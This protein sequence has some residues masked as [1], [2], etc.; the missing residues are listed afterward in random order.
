MLSKTMNPTARH[1]WMFTVV[2]GITQIK[3]ANLQ[4]FKWD[5]SQKHHISLSFRQM[6]TRCLTFS[7]LALPHQECSS[8]VLQVQKEPLRITPCDL[9]KIPPAKVG[10][11]ESLPVCH[12][13]SSADSRKRLDGWKTGFY[14]RATGKPLFTF[15]CRCAVDKNR[16]KKK[17]KA[18]FGKWKWCLRG[19]QGEDYVLFCLDGVWWSH[20][21]AGDITALASRQG[22][23]KPPIPFSVTWG[24]E[25]KN[26]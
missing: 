1:R 20:V 13:T 14:W 4:Y 8:S 15:T 5:F 24:R 19:K 11:R 25:K 23:S 2:L 21:V 9:P 22:T 17:K 7:G 26:N 18:M 12:R 3:M 16:K 10:H 6:H